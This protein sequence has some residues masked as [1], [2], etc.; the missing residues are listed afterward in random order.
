MNRPPWNKPV[1][2]PSVPPPKPADSGLAPAPAHRRDL[3]IA[4]AARKLAEACEVATTALR[5]F[6][7]AYEAK[8]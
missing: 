3:E 4:E 6:I 2:P 5:K 1:T 8:Q 7:E